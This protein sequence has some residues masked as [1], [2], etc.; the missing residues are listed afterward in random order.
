MKTD[1]LIARLSAG[2]VAVPAG[3]RWRRIGVA[4]AL[5]VVAAF[6]VLMVGWGPRPDLHLAMRTPPFWMKAGYTAAPAAAGLLL[7]DR[8]GR[9]GARAGV[10]LALL[11]AA[12]AAILMLAA[13][14]LM[15]MPMADW[16][17][18]MMGHSARVCPLRIVV[19]AAPGVRAGAVGAEAHGPDPPGALAGAAAGLLAGGLAATVYGL[20][21]NETAA[22]FTAAWYTLG[23]GVWAAI[24][25]LVGPRLLRW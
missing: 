6:A 2:T 16:R 17:A 25:A 24:G 13:Y 14:E 20:G 21:C 4:A 18:D 1:D 7:V 12:V 22:A 8:S 9:P 23:V 19:M 5:A 15:R 3:V 11:A 10:G